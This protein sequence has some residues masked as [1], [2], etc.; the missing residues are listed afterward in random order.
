ME[1]RKTIHPSDNKVQRNNI[2]WTLKFHSKKISNLNFQIE[3]CENLLENEKDPIKK[4][5]LK[6]DIYHFQ[7]S[8]ADSEEI[9]NRCNRSLSKLK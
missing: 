7:Q 9:V 4:S 2:L 3:Q 6:S 5:D 1:T 8:I